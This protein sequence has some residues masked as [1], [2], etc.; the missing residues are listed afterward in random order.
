MDSENYIK[1]I[2]ALPSIQSAIQIS[3]MK[4]GAILKLE[5]PQSE[6]ESIVKLSSLAGEIFE[7]IIIPL[8]KKVINKKIR[9]LKDKENE[10]SKTNSFEDSRR[11]SGK[12]S[13]KQKR[14][15]T[16]TG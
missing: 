8:D 13:V 4:D 7:V 14:A 16:A 15:K 9:Y 6:I 5:I 12:T 1:F 11:E 2:A 10:S 3:G